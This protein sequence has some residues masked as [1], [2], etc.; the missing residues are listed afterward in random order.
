M[1]HWLEMKYVTVFLRLLAT[2]K[3]LFDSL[4][5]SSASFRGYLAGIFVLSWLED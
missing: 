4:M 5:A 1:N 3:W 2:A